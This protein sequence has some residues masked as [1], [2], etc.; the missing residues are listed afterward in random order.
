MCIAGIYGA[1][2]F[3][4][5]SLMLLFFTTLAVVASPGMDIGTINMWSIF[6][7]YII[8]FGGTIWG[9]RKMFFVSPCGNENA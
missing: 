8:G 3:I 2:G 7:P 5:T 1:L 6:V 9:V 4:Q